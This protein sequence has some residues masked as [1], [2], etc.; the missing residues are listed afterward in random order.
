MASRGYRP[1]LAQIR[2]FVTIADTK[3]FGTAATKLSIS[4]PSLSQALVALETG[5]GV[6]LIERSTRRVIVT[7]VGESLLPFAKATLDAADK[8]LAH[9]QGVEGAL[10]GPLTI[11]MIP[12]AAPYILPSLLKIFDA[13]FKELQPRIVEAQT[14]PLIDRLRDGN[15]DV[16]LL[17][18]P[19]GSHSLVE[20]PL[21]D[22]EFVVVVQEDHPFAGRTDLT[23]ESL[24]DLELLLLDDGHCLR[25]Q[26]I[27]LC[28]MVSVHPTM[29]R[30]AIAQASSLATVMQCVA[31]GLGATLIPL[32]AIDAETMRPGIATARFAPGV[33]AYRTIGIAYRTSSS[34][35]EEFNKFGEV[36]KR[37]FSLVTGEAAR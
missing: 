32:S 29:T 21:Y 24:R 31:G 27:D 22:E 3:H 16:A 35:A 9:A 18:I 6:Q 23:L 4:Q 26:I 17:A 5:L 14:Q 13:E 7:P 36:V 12:T 33:N 10:G 8:F 19:S 15:I 30:S 25:D 20:I 11:G 28:R 37:A 34:R 1:T 2:T